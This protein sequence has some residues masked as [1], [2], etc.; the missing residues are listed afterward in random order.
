MRPIIRSSTS[1][2]SRREL[3]RA[4]RPTMRVRTLLAAAAV[5]TLA[6]CGDSKSDTALNS[7]SVLGR[8]LAMAATDTNALP[9]LQDVPT[10]PP[11]VEAPVVVAPRPKPTPKPVRPRS[12]PTAT[13][14]T[15]TPAPRGAK[16]GVLDAGTSLQ[17]AANAK[18]CSN[19]T[20]VGEKFS[21]QLSQSVSGSN[22]VMIPAGTTGTFQVT[23][24]RTAK[25]SNDATALK[26]RLISVTIGGETYP[27][28]STLQMASTERVRSAS[29]GT[30]AKK[31]AGGAVIGAIAGQIIGKNTKG[32]VIGAAAGAA[33]GTAAAAATAD[34]DT[35]LNSGS[36]ITVTLDGPVTV[37]IAN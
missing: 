24:A 34:Y 2:V 25:N 16:T 12:A 10:M 36:A 35:C 3:A 23:E 32:T 27:V 14:P 37:R 21:A 17:F 30:D 5:V 15:P 18:V 11:P 22:G 28:E 8:D 26:A 4:I 33:A 20:Q 19:T 6:A 9:K 1:L 29:K 13:A 7:D 31:V